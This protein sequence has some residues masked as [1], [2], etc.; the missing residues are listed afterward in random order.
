[1]HIATV[2]LVAIDSAVRTGDASTRTSFD[3]ADL[4]AGESPPDVEA[5]LNHPVTARLF[6]NGTA[7]TPWPDAPGANRPDPRWTDDI[8]PYG[9]DLNDPS[10]EDPAAVSTTLGPR[11]TIS[12]GMTR[13]ECESDGDG[14][15]DDPAVWENVSASASATGGE[16]FEVGDDSTRYYQYRCGRSGA[17]GPAPADAVHVRASPEGTTNN[18]LARFGGDRLPVTN[19]TTDAPVFEALADR[20]LIDPETN[21]VTL[22]SN[23]ALFLY[24]LDVT[25]T[26]SSR[27]G[28]DSQPRARYDDGVV[29]VT[30]RER[31]TVPRGHKLR[32]TKEP[33]PVRRVRDIDGDGTVTYADVVTLFELIDAEPVAASPLSFDYNENGRVDFADLVALFRRVV[34]G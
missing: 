1:V 3:H 16:A 31:A 15:Y 5:A 13:Y 25:V 17:D 22:P 34:G 33:T 18:V 2:K 26:G 8:D 19:A 24:E 9:D 6:V 21:T 30:F 10:G 20:R 32:V 7:Y 11:Y 27:Q 28:D 12:V 29:L 4:V 14:T 23:A